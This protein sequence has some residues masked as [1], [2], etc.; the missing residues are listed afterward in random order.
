MQASQLARLRDDGIIQRVAQCQLCRGVFEPSAVRGLLDEFD[1]NISVEGDFAIESRICD[2]AFARGEVNRQHFIRM[3]TKK[4]L[5]EEMRN[6]AVNNDE[7]EEEGEA[8]THGVPTN[9]VEVDSVTESAKVEC[10]IVAAD[11]QQGT[12]WMF[13]ASA[14][15]G[16]EDEEE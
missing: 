3:M 13:N 2:P 7:N 11:W 12:T 10:E 6:F 4:E 14:H 1:L 9:H 8:L 16:E 5:E 15:A